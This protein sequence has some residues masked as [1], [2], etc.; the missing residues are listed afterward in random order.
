MNK[1]YSN[2]EIYEIGNKFLTF[3]EDNKKYFPA[4]IA[5]I[6]QKNKKNLTVLLEEIEN[7]RNEIFKEYG[8]ILENGQVQIP[9]EKIEIVNKE[10]EDLLN[11]KQNIEIITLPFEDIEKLEF[12]MEQMEALLFMIEEPREEVVQEEIE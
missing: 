1:N 11:I 4:K 2:K 12:T 8:N 3:F 9:K 6:I 10:L 5:F 7:S